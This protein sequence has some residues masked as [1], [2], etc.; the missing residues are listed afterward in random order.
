MPAFL[1]CFFVDEYFN[2]V[3]SCMRVVYYV[4]S[5]GVIL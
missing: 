2:N 4:S 3:I 5:S 1:L